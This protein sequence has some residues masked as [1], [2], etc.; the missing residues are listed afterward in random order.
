MS[1]SFIFPPLPEDE[2]KQIY[3]RSIYIYIFLEK[4]FISFFLSL[5]YHLFVCLSFSP[6]FALIVIVVVIS[7]FLSLNPHL[8]VCLSF[9]PSFGLVVMYHSRSK[10][11]RHMRERV[12]SFRLAALRIAFVCLFT[13][14][15]RTPSGFPSFLCFRYVLLHI[16]SEYHAQLAAK[17]SVDKIFD[18]TAGVYF[19][20][21]N[22]VVISLG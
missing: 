5:Y 15:F 8:F 21:N 11:T 1:L 4:P 13:S 18:L 2:K 19:Y 3:T 17:I 6:S 12:N 22:N 20:F 14:R 9:S 16:V 10:P 7:F